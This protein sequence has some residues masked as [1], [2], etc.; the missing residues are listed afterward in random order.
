MTDPVS[1]KMTL[2]VIMV[3]QNLWWGLSEG[4]SRESFSRDWSSQPASRSTVQPEA[5]VGIPH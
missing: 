3:S 4:R 2:I 1:W 5:V